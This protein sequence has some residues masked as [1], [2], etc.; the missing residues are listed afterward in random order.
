LAAAPATWFV[1]VLITVLLVLGY[2]LDAA[3]G[4]L[5]RLRGGGSSM[6]E[7]LDHMID[8]AKVVGLHLAVLINLYRNFDLH[9]GWLLVPIVFAIAS[10]VHF[11][12]MILVDLLGRAR[13]AATGLPNASPAP[14]DK[15]KTMLKLPTDYGIFCLVFL[16]LGWHFGFLVLYTFFAV[17]TVGYTVLVVGKW[18]RDMIQLDAIGRG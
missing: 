3:D 8:S 15:L 14:A 7:W 12:G 2:A 17:A 16:F 5:A 6:G 18:R 10:S 1:G 9:P 11:F 13:R 4:Q